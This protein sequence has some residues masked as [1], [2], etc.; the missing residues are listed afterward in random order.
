MLCIENITNIFYIFIIFLPIVLI[1]NFNTS[2]LCYKIYYIFIRQFWYNNNKIIL[3]EKYNKKYYI[4][5]PSL[6][7]L[8][9]I[10][11]I[12]NMYD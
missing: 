2:K 8:F 11:H 3:I 4:I 12:C 1:F 9:D 7:K 10:I 6:E 5:F